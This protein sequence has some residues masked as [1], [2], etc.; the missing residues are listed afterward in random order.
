[1]KNA[2]QEVHYPPKRSILITGDVVIFKLLQRSDEEALKTFFFQVPE[3]E[4]ESLRDDV[5]NPDT[6]AGWIA[7]LNYQKVLPLVSWDEAEES[8]VGVSSL[9]F[10][11]GV[12]RHIADV[13]IF[14]GKGYRRLGLGSIM[15][16]ELIDIGN[17]LGLY[18][19]RAETLAENQLA[20]KAFRQLG[21]ESKCN[22]E[23]GFL[24]LKR[25]ETRDVVL[26]MKRLQVSLEEDFFYVF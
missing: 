7:S 9:H 23:D 19:L 1:M 17:R 22:L 21:F 2:V 26:M 10:M 20:V 14:I 15:I 4:A 25:G 3:N 18:F 5:R 16:K 13:R 12:Y 6:V 8:I 11:Q 24:S